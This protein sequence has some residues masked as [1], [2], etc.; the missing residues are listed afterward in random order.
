[1]SANVEVEIS[2]EH[3]SSISEIKESV[4]QDMI[5]QGIAVGYVDHQVEEDA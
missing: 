3:Q 4:G 2:E 1:M 5:A